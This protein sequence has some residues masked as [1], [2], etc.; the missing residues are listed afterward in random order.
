MFE[1]K[2]MYSGQKLTERICISSQHTKC[3][4]LFGSTCVKFLKVEQ[5]VIS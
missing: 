4:Q 1:T 2:Y 3:M 5:P